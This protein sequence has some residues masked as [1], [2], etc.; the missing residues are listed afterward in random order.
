[1][2]SINYL[3]AIVVGALQGV[4]EL[5]PVSSLGHSVLFPALVGGRWASDLSMTGTDSPYLAV[6][7]AM[8]VATALALGA[9]AGR[10]AGLAVAAGHDPGRAGRAGA[11]ARP[12]HHARP[13]G[14]GGDLPRPERRGALRGRADAAAGGAGGS[15]G[16]GAGRLAGRR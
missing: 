1:M 3:E 10:A 2:S 9:D 16:S 4:S 5:F 13:S 8:H 12:A 7:V 11:G 14:A 6:L 15:G